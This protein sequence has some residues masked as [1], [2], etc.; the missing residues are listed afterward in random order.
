M[1]RV[2]RA[3]T[4]AL[5]MA[6]MLAAQ[7]RAVDRPTV[8]ELFTA[9]GCSSCP[10]AEAALGVLAQRPDVLALAFHVDYW[11]DVG[12]PDHFQLPTSARRQAQYVRRLKLPV[13]AT[14]QMIVNGR[15]ALQGSNQDRLNTLLREA[16]AGEPIQLALAGQ[17]LTIDVPA[18][19]SGETCDVILVSYLPQATTHVRRGENAG[20]DLKEYNI[21]RSLRVLGSPG[22]RGAHWQLSRQSLPPDAE[23][24]A[25]WLQ[26]AGQGPIIGAT[27]L[28]L[29]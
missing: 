8:I 26:E 5:C 18:L 2:A 19:T 13:A 12:W 24:V 20:R 4:A 21:V 17:V 25:V 11:D 10:P 3:I 16:S 27:S 6:V 28:A 9:Q 22:P 14:P 23:R 1:I 7:A 29:R 15:L